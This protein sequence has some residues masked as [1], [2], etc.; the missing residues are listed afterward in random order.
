MLLGGG[1]TLVLMILEKSD[2]TPQWFTSLGLDAA[3]YGIAVSLIAF[4]IG[5]ILFKDKVKQTILVK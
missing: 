4:V 3:V 1:F 5:S 2:H